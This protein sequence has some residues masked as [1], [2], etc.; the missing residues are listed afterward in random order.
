MTRNSE[1]I[2]SNM[3]S[4]FDNCDGLS[5]WQYGR[6]RVWK[7][8]ERKLLMEQGREEERKKEEL[9]G[10]REKISFSFSPVAVACID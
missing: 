1:N 5:K 7:A 4:L 3:F 2:T 10:A 9:K 6:W 8:A